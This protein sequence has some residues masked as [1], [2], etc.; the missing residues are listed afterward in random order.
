MA[1]WAVWRALRARRHITL[2]W[3]DL[4]DADGLYELDDEGRAT[5]TLAAQLSRRQRRAALA[6]ELVHDERR[7]VFDDETPMGIVRK[8]EALVEAEA[9][10]R[11]VPLGDLADLVFAREV[12]TIDDIVEEF[13]VPHEV[14]ER[15]AKL[16]R[17]RLEHLEE[18]R[19]RAP[20]HPSLR[21]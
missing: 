11:L 17:A 8:E 16:H 18:L 19:R 14:A 21:R 4:S 20:R 1:G 5:I 10:R 13:D 3:A 2:E 7:I 12:V 6:H 15:A 9:V